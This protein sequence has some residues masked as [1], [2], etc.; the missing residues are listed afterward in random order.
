MWGSKK[1]P[2]PFRGLDRRQENLLCA[3]Q[4]SGQVQ[5][6][7]SRLRNARNNMPPPEQERST[8]HEG[9]PTD[10]FAV[11]N[12]TA[13]SGEELIDEIVESDTESQVAEENQADTAAPQP[14]ASHGSYSSGPK[15]AGISL[16]TYD[17]ETGREDRIFNRTIS[18][19]GD[20]YP[21]PFSQKAKEHYTPEHLAIEQDLALKARNE[22]KRKALKRRRLEKWEKR[23]E[24]LEEIEKVLASRDGDQALA[25]LENTRRFLSDKEKRSSSPKAH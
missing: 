12:A 25:V 16:G 8:E 1:V 14:S 21:A 22:P 20:I 3:P 4:G 9:S 17:P 2:L 23:K 11:E 5:E 6:S 10:V 7:S 19:L 13:D 18:Y 24:L 15:F